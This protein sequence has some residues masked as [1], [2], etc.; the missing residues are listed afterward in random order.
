MAT[1]FGVLAWRVP[2]TEEPGGLQSM[3][4]HRVGHDWSDLAVSTVSFCFIHI[5]TAIKWINICD[6][7]VFL[8]ISLW[9]HPNFIIMKRLSL[10]YSY[11]LSQSVFVYLSLSKYILNCLSFYCRIIRTLYISQVEFLCQI[12]VRQTSFSVRPSFFIFLT[13]DKE[14]KFFML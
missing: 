8:I 12:H 6:Y 3:G 14:Q 2:W 1:H 7:Y 4:S 13:G 10:L 11:N 9:N 5:K